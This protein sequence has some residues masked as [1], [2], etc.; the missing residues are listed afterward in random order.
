[1]LPVGELKRRVFM[2]IDRT[3]QFIRLR[4]YIYSG[5]E[6]FLDQ[7]GTFLHSYS[8][9]IR[10][11]LVRFFKDQGEHRFQKYDN[12]AKNESYRGYRVVFS[13]IIDFL[14]WIISRSTVRSFIEYSTIIRDI[15][16]RSSSIR[17][18]L[19]SNDHFLRNLT[20]K[21]MKFCFV[22]IYCRKV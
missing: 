9:L 19:F 3:M 12:R 13:F 2:I 1:M 8:V 15:Q 7:Y 16:N 21:L 4:M 14:Y 17:R 11:I 10:R 22:D 18:Q 5:I 20:C 6:I